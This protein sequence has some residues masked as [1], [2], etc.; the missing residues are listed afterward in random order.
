MPRRPKKPQLKK[1]TSRQLELFPS[2]SSRVMALSSSGK[3]KRG[4]GI[5]PPP[6]EVQFEPLYVKKHRSG[7]LHYDLRLGWKGAFF[8]FVLPL[9]PDNGPGSR[10]KAIRMEDHHGKDAGLEG[11]IPRGRFGAGLHM[12]WDQGMWKPCPEDADLNACLRKGLLRFTLHGAKLKGD[13]SLRRISGSRTDRP[14]TVWEL[15]KQ[16]DSSARG[17]TARSLL[18]QAPASVLTGRTLDQIERD[19]H[20]AKRRLEPAPKLFEP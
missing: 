18:D 5:Q 1:P 12:L 16:P 14:G 3:Q 8:S 20:A 9:G 7:R 17:E 11:V 13:W 2:S 6:S 15:V 19:D 10:Q 4:T